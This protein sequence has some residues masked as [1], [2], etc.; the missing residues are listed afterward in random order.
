MS[1]VTDPMERRDDIRLQIEQ[2]WLSRA[3]AQGLKPGTKAYK[4]REVEFFV[5][6]MA[7]MQAIAPNNDHPEAMTAL[8][9]PAWTVNIIAGRPIVETK[10]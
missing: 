1:F 7:A 8:A 5:G 9:P 4:D 3:K 10:R 6:V 2:T